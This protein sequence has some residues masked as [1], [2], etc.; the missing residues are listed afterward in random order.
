MSKRSA[1]S[2]CARRR[3]VSL[4]ARAPPANVC[5]CV[6]AA[7]SVESLAKCVVAF[8]AAGKRFA[9]PA[10]VLPSTA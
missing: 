10:E 8:A 7:A 9:P 1:C 6:K 3:P 5:S 4:N 2:P